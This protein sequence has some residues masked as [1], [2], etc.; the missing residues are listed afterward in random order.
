MNSAEDAYDDPIEVDSSQVP[1]CHICN[2]A[3]RMYKCPRCS[4]F[5]CSL[6]C[7]KKHKQIMNCNGKRD[8]TEFV[9][10]RDFTGS[11]L[12][13]DFHF[14][15]DVLQS[16]DR[17]KRTIST[18]CG[19]L[20]SQD[21]YQ[22]RKRD[23]LDLQAPNVFHKQNLD[24]VPGRAKKLALSAF[25]RKTNLM[26]MPAGMSKRNLNSSKFVE[27]LKKIYWRIHFIF[28]L[29]DSFHLHEICKPEGG[30]VPSNINP[31]S[32]EMF[33]DRPFSIYDNSNLLSVS[34]SEA[35]EAQTLENLM[36]EFFSN[37]PDNAALRY[38]L[39]YRAIYLLYCTILY[40]T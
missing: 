3:D 7:C 29:A 21:N 1:K 10:I 31:H 8:Q 15:E 36:D 12:R 27:K 33:I 34:I 38:A 9:N 39:R 35:D 40:F 26:I 5:T 28:I 6:E 23:Q 30:Y 16:K 14:L 13:N 11:H 18:K 4:T 22:K 17:A 19:G 20:R 32:S 37:R 2:E 24:N 25:E